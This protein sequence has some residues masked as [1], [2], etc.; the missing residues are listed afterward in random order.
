MTDQFRS[1]ARIGKV[2]A[3]PSILHGVK[4]VQTVPVAMA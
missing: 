2:T 3:P 1:D 4:G